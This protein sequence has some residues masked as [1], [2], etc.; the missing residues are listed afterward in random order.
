MN[1]DELLRSIFPG[2]ENPSLTA[3]AGGSSGILT[4]KTVDC[5]RRPT[6]GGMTLEDFLSKAGVAKGGAEKTRGHQIGNVGFVPRPHWLQQYH[7]NQQQQAQQ[8]IVG[9]YGS[10]QVYQDEEGGNSSPSDPQTPRRKRGP[11]E[12]VAKKMVERR[13]KRM[14]KNRESAARSRAR[15]QACL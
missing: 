14:I 2:E 1:L 3:D 5:R 4:K 15:K 12:D 9:A 6:L 11:L 7:Q 10:Q 8:S 13:Q